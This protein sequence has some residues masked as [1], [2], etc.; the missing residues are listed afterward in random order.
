[1][2]GYLTGKIINKKE[3][4]LTVFINGI[5]YLIRVP[6]RI[7]SS[8]EVG[9]EIELYIHTHVRED[10]LELFGFESE[11]ELDF[12]HQLISVS[13]IGPKSALGILDQPLALIKSAIF[14]GDEAM[15]TTLPGI[16]RKT[17]GRL[18]LELK[19]KIS[20]DEFQVGSTKK[21]DANSDAL[22]ALVSLGYDRGQTLRT[23]KDLPTEITKT[24][25]IV[26]W[27]LKNA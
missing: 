24:E 19:N 22:E 3:N 12:F 5:G 11:K 13:G 25:E 7:A 9:C 26:K 20:L 15:L 1:M 27:F 8:N 18:I 17:A 4:S 23:L 6:T 10:A 16:G 14:S 21:I 2:I